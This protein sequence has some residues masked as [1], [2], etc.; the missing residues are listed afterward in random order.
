MHD[1]KKLLH[2]GGVSVVSNIYLGWGAGVYTMFAQSLLQY[3]GR[4]FYFLYNLSAVNS[5]YI[6]V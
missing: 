2:Q 1:I 5:V 3:V 4:G 6:C